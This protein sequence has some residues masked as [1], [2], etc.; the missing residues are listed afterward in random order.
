MYTCIQYVYNI[1]IIIIIT[2]INCKI[3]EKLK[4]FK[5]NNIIFL[6]SILWIYFL[7]KKLVWNFILNTAV[8]TLII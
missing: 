4:I 5:Y 7:K 1:I 8:Y 6:Y 2:I 3:A